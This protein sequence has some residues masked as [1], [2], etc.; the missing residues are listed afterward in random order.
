M[1]LHPSLIMPPQLTHERF[2]FILKTLLPHCELRQ[3]FL[4]VPD[5]HF[6]AGEDKHLIKSHK[7]LPFPSSILK[8]LQQVGVF[9]FTFPVSLVE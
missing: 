4:F 7:M 3:S 8:I 9:N 6:T 2:S 5:K 1:L